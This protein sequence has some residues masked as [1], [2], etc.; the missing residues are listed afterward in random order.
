MHV[1]GYMGARVPQHPVM[2]C[3]PPGPPAVVRATGLSAFLLDSSTTSHTLFRNLYM[4]LDATSGI[5]AGFWV[6]GNL[7]W[8]PIASSATFEDI[9]V[10]APNP[11]VEHFGWLL[12]TSAVEPVFLS[13]CT[14]NAAGSEWVYG[15]QDFGTAPLVLD[16]CS[17]VNFPSNLTGRSCG[18]LTRSSPSA[19]GSA[20]V[21]VSHTVFDESFTN[22]IMIGRLEE[23][24]S[25]DISVANCIVPR[26]LF[27]SFN[28]EFVSNIV[29]TNAALVWAGFPTPESP[30]VA[31]GMGALAPLANDPATDTDGDGFCDYV[32]VYEKG[33]DPYL[34]D[35]DLDGISD[36]DEDQQGTDPTNPHSF[37]QNLTVTVTNTVS[38]SHDAYLAWGYYET[39][40]EANEVVMFWSGAGSNLYVNASS[41]GAEYVKAFCD[42]DDDGVF[43]AA[44]DILIATR[45]P[46]GTVANVSFRFGD[47][48]GDGVTDEQEREDG[49]DPYDDRSFKINLFAR[50]EG[51][52]HTTNALSV[53][54]AMNTNTL[55][56]PVVLDMTNRVWTFGPQSLTAVTGGRPT[57]VF[58]DDVN[59][60]GMCEAFETAVTYT[61]SPFAHDMAFTNRLSYGAFDKDNDGMMDWWEIQHGLSPTNTVDAVEDLD[62]DGLINLHEQW[63]N[64]DPNIP[65]G[66]N[67]VLSVISRSVNDRLTG[68]AS[69]TS[70]GK[71]L[72]YRTTSGGYSYNFVTNPLFW[73]SDVDTSCASMWN[74][75]PWP[76][77]FR[78]A[79]TLISPRHMI[80]AAHFPAVVDKFVWFKGANGS[81]YSNKVVAVTSVSGTDIQ[82]GLLE[83]AVPESIVKPA[84]L[85]PLDF[86]EYISIGKLL[87]VMQFDYD[88]HGVV[89]EIT[90]DL[91]VPGS[92]QMAEARVC[93]WKPQSAIRQLFYE[94]IVIGDS[95]NPMFLIIGNDAVLLGAAHVGN[96][97]VSD[98]VYVGSGHPF[99]TYYA[100]EV[101]TAMDALAT[102]YNLRFYDFSTYRRLDE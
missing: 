85:L 21:S 20:E 40:W 30:S 12:Y 39:G 14:V 93:T 71:F 57:F 92:V 102:G 55:Y 43:T 62:G 64:C 87:P 99:L 60:N 82:I 50:I 2:I 53:L 79:G 42:L 81:T 66:S 5:Q 58:W 27:S 80:F 97:Y 25:N 56:G 36:Y 22:A 34:V 90:S 88:E 68:K 48:D 15:V 95:G 52:F 19:G 41:N 18:I 31:L 1:V 70:I 24:I 47:V 78:K 32:E 69:T 98:G 75:F 91:P 28:L 35:S 33:T 3:A 84:M 13:R 65:D 23:G 9:Y 38:L 72:N 61:P 29:V 67:T 45:I 74:S 101:Q 63:A 4:L 6:G 26:E 37:L 11:G 86:A 89:Y 7:P 96:G 49:T 51:L 73:A 16:C 17:F 44:T 59:C 10:R 46:T 54:V 100:S 83:T 94:N 76:G 77:E 8:Y